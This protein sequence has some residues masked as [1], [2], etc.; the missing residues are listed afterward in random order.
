MRIKR[1]LGHLLH[2]SAI[3]AIVAFTSQA[4]ADQNV[5]KKTTASS[6]GPLV[7]LHEC[8][9]GKEVWHATSK[10]AKPPL[11]LAAAGFCERHGGDGN[12]TCEKGTCAGSCSFH[13]IGSYCTC[14]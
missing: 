10:S 6:S 8:K 12:Y 13:N 2:L 9:T 11:L 3:A 4:V 1:L 7:A 14:D 5:S